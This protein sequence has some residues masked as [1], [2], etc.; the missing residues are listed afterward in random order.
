MPSSLQEIDPEDAVRK[1]TNLFV[2]QLTSEWNREKIPYKLA[3]SLETARSAHENDTAKIFLHTGF[4]AWFAYFLANHNTTGRNYKGQR[5]D[6]Q[7]LKAFEQQPIERRK[8]VAVELINTETHTTV[9]SAIKQCSARKRRRIDNMESPSPSSPSAIPAAIQ[10]PDETRRT[11]SEH[12]ADARTFR[13]SFTPHPSEIP[14]NMTEILSAPQIVS[15][16][17]IECLITIFPQYLCSAIRKSDGRA[18]ITIVFPS[19]LSGGKLDCIMTLAIL[20]NKIQYLVM[21]LFGIHLETE[22]EIRCIIQDNGVRLFPNDLVL[23]GVEEKIVA[24]VLGSMANNAITK[25]LLRKE[26]V[27]NAMI[28]TQCVS[29]RIT[30]NCRD[31]GI[32]SLNLGLD[33]GFQF[34]EALFK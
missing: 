18:G 15:N 10:V 13:S 34:K 1:A 22:G 6:L 9:T 19:H 27:K 20:P 33:E 30:S 24:K 8:A 16:P 7:A 26:E 3:S 14:L 31:D 28:A 32:L 11:E 21:E 25:S 17:A 12:A 5:A 2:R 29:L 4:P 23:Q